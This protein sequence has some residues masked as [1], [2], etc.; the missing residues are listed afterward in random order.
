MRQKRQCMPMHLHLHTDTAPNNNSHGYSPFLVLFLKHRKPNSLKLN[1]SPSYLS[2]FCAFI[3]RP[4]APWQ[5]SACQPSSLAREIR[6]LMYQCTPFG[7]LSRYSASILD[8][9]GIWDRLVSLGRHATKKT[10]TTISRALQNG[11]GTWRLYT[12]VVRDGLNCHRL[13]V[14]S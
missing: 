7:Y 13:M 6:C 11:Y 14:E 8:P 10:Q 3:V 2:P 12:L 4:A 5:H 1:S 9:N